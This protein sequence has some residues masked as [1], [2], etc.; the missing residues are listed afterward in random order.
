MA[1]V[2]VV[3]ANSYDS[4][5]VDQAMTELLAHL[6]GMSKY[7]QPGER[8]LVKPN[9]LEGLPPEKAVTTHP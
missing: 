6:A 4:Q 1:K 9:L 2:A 8:V 3:Q 7:I 5:I